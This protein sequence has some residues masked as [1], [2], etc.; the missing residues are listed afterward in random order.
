MVIYIYIY[1]NT[2]KIPLLLLLL[3]LLLLPYIIFIYLKDSASVPVF[4][5]DT[6]EVHLKDDDDDDNNDDNE[7]EEEEKDKKERHVEDIFILYSYH[8]MNK[9]SHY[10]FMNEIHKRKQTK[11]N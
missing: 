9:H 11:T 7:Q 1:I 2:L 10:K 3:L 4:T 8:I 5:I 6:N